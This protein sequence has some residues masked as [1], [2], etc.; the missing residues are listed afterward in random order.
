MKCEVVK[1]LLALYADDVCSDQTKKDIE[2]HLK[3]CEVCSKSLEDYKK[4]INTEVVSADNVEKIKPF[5]KISKKIRIITAITT[6]LAL[7]ITAFSVLIWVDKNSY[8]LDYS[9]FETYILTKKQNKML[10]KG[11]IDG[12]MNNVQTKE[13][14]GGYFI[15]DSDRIRKDARIELN[16][17]YN[18][19]LKDK[20]FKVKDIYVT[21][22][23]FGTGF[24]STRAVQ[25]EMETKDEKDIT[26]LYVW[27]NKKCS[28]SI[29][30]DKN[31]GKEFERDV[32]QKLNPLISELQLRFDYYEIIKN[33][34]A[35]SSA[36][37]ADL[38]QFFARDFYSQGYTDDQKMQLAQRMEAM[39][40]N[41]DVLSMNM[42]GVKYDKENKQFS[43][44]FTLTVKDYKTGKIAIMK[45]T[46]V[47]CY[48][49]YIPK[50]DAKLIANDGISP[51]TEKQLLELL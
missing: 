6:V 30:A 44:D 17:F 33:K 11:D 16:N 40:K 39:C 48:S 1:D 36:E 9:L 38:Y 5:K 51:E 46:L 28:I 32:N 18:K 23:G 3:E 25:V 50:D 27:V 26:L 2:E 29:Y 8:N 41:A 14:D 49:Y 22:S 20:N 47:S 42:S 31:Y 37:N 12:F 15:N 10:L 45:Q 19:Y 13:Y 34:S 7:I 4:E 21:Y 24:D 43:L 35:K